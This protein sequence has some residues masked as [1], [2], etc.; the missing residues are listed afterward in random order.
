MKT[1]PNTQ[2][3]LALEYDLNLTR[4]DTKGAMKE[5]GASSGD[6]W[7]VGIENVRLLPNFNVRVKNEKYH[8][9]VRSIADSMLQE[10]FKKDKPL[11]GYVAKEDGNNVIFVYGGHR[12][13][14]AVG[15]ANAEGAEIK[16][17][18]IVVAPRGTTMEDLTVDLV[19]GN[20]GDALEPFEVAIVAKRLV[21]Y[22]WEVS[23]IAKR[24]GRTE[25][26]VNGLLSLMESPKAL[27]DMVQRDEVAA[28][29]AI[30]LLQEH[31]NGSKVVQILEIGLS[32]AK[33]A[34]KSRL[35]PKFIPGAV[36]KKA[37]I[38]SAPVLVST[39]K[40]LRD[41]PGYAKLSPQFQDKIADLLARL[42]EAEK[43]DA[44]QG[45]ESTTQ[46]DE[47]AAQLDNLDMAEE[48]DSPQRS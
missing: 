41:D 16:T 38:K 36:Y 25:T 42:D 17:V 5:A 21:G 10:G 14:E 12:R 34:G 3:E 22:Q 9:R 29:T 8:A 45:L 20:N 2:P 13:W 47:I 48:A 43:A 27:R 40:D 6:L 44:K 37:V 35:T 26:Y 33:A 32:R 11:S 30:E 4:G 24:L 15:I 23:Q 19:T 1:S 18:P 46:D 28:S 31:G 39:L 7:N